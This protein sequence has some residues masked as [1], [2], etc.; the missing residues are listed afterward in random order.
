LDTEGA[1][2][3][4]GWGV[5]SWLVVERVRNGGGDGLELGPDMFLLK[6]G[7][8]GGVVSDRVSAQQA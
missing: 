2:G 6:D 3:E 8:R 7:A 5:S 4:G 1:G